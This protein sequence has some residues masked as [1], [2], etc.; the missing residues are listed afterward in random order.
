MIRSW[1]RT[2]RRLATLGA[3]ALTVLAA[4]CA[5]TTQPSLDTSQLLAAGFK[6]V[7][8][9]TEAQQAQLQS[10]PTGQITE[11]QRTGKR[12]F[13][14]PDVAGKRLFVGTPTE[15]SAY[16]RLAS[17]TAPAMARQQE[18]DLASYNKQDATMQMLT[19]RDLADPYYF[20]ESFDGLGWQ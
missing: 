2:A 14:Y 5:G 17:G 20:W 1:R 9:R 18:S 16:L 4:G 10:L 19:K 13:V 11:W 7:A 3:L 8:A 15:Y 6:I 12:Y